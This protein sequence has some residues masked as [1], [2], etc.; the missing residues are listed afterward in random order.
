M[1]FR[2][3]HIIIHVYQISSAETAIITAKGLSS[4]YCD[5]AMLIWSGDDMP[6]NRSNFR[7][8]DRQATQQGNLESG[9]IAVNIYLMPSTFCL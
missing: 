3:Y 9:D 4:D 7:H 8:F 5:F 2:S 6:M 1:L